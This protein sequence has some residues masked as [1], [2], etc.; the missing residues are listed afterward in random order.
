VFS[1]DALGV[2]IKFWRTGVPVWRCSR[3]GTLDW[4]PVPGVRTATGLSTLAALEKLLS[5]RR[6]LLVWTRRIRDPSL[7]NGGSGKSI[8][9]DE[10]VVLTSWQSLPWG[11][12][13]KRWNEVFPR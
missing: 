3:E 10:V 5:C 11:P 7:S 13:N 6:L 12:S 8:M 2:A 1:S 9:A 4:L